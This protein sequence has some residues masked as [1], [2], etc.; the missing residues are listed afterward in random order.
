[1]DNHTVFN[2]IDNTPAYNLQMLI[3]I[4]FYYQNNFPEEYLQK[5]GKVIM[6]V[7]EMSDELAYRINVRGTEI[8]SDEGKRVIL[9]DSSRIKEF[10]S[11]VVFDEQ[12]VQRSLK[13][14]NDLLDDIINAFWNRGNWFYE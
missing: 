2:G 6:M 4:L 14:Y 12:R 7:L 11:Y 5:V 1:M 10:A 8:V 13:D 3:D 9:P